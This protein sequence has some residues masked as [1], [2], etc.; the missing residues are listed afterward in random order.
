MYD[1]ESTSAHTQNTVTSLEE[2]VK[3]IVLLDVS[4]LTVSVSF[5]TPAESAKT[6]CL[7]LPVDSSRCSNV[8][9]C[10]FS[11]SYIRVNWMFQCFKMLARQ[12]KRISPC[13]FFFFIDTKN[14]QMMKW[15]AGCSCRVL[16]KTVLYNRK[17]VAVAFSS[18]WH[19]CLQLRSEDL[20][21]DWRGKMFFF[22]ML[23][24]LHLCIIQD[25]YLKFSYIGRSCFPSRL[26]HVKQYSVLC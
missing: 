23:R 7:L 22:L 9:C 13:F 5:N 10:C 20:R 26:L 12:N 21:K 25:C 3:N 17:V 4:K 15:I 14:E 11:S 18:L 8:R 24:Q 2:L 16:W 6:N 1:H 19:F